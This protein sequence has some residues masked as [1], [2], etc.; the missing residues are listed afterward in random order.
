MATVV[1]LAFDMKGLLARRR[2]RL[3]RS[4]PSVLLGGHAEATL[5]GG[6]ELRQG[7]TISTRANRCPTDCAFGADQYCHR[8]RHTAPKRCRYALDAT[9]SSVPLRDQ[10]VAVAG[11]AQ[12]G[13]RT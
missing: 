7:P 2:A 1:S 13:G 8:R 9:P 12:R 10:H 3:R 5:D 11:R 6:W 4:P